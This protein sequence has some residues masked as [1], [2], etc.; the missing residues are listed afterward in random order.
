MRNVMSRSLY[1]HFKGKF[2]YVIDVALDSETQTEMVVYQALYG[3]NK[4]WVRP[5]TMFLSEVDEGKENP[6]GQKYRFEYYQD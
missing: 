4:L 3:D 1:R 5:K 6:T 2:Y